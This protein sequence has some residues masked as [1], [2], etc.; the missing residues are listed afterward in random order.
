LLI[1]LVESGDQPAAA[2]ATS[3][4]IPGCF[5]WL[6]QRFDGARSIAATLAETPGFAASVPGQNGRARVPRRR[7]A[8][9]RPRH[10]RGRR[11]GVRRATAGRRTRRRSTANDQLPPRSPRTPAP[12]RPSVSEPTGQVRRRGKADAGALGAGPPR[13]AVRHRGLWRDRWCRTMGASL[14]LLH[15]KTASCFVRII[16]PKKREHLGT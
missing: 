11:R 3:C 15:H 8:L 13:S 16:L 4:R 14:K 10:R 9:K 12:A 5:G 1:A 2:V 6:V 7:S